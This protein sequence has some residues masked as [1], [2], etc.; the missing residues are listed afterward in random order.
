MPQGVGVKR[1]RV[2]YS[3]HTETGG[4]SSKTRDFR[5]LRS[6]GEFIRDLSGGLEFSDICSMEVQPLSDQEKQALAMFS[7]GAYEP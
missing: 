5:S 4:Y 7:D 2:R 1:Y 6:A 3:V